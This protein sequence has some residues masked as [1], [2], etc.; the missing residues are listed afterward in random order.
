[1]AHAPQSCTSSEL[2][3]L[4]D[5][6]LL[7]PSG[8]ALIVVAT[9]SNSAETG[10]PWCP[11]C[12]QAKSAIDG[13]LQ[14]AAESHVAASVAVC[15]LSRDEWKSEHGQTNHPLRLHSQL[16]VGGIPFVARVVDGKIVG[17]ATEEEC[18]S[19][20]DLMK[21]LKT[22]PPP[23]PSSSAALPHPDADMFCEAPPAP[24]MMSFSS[25]R[26]KMLLFSGGKKE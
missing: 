10:M 2:I 24:K 26:E 8:R 19:M 25:G 6:A 3:T 1:M 9:A 5:H 18:F 20:E 23:P 16:M 21:R 15:A 17:R 11:D 7:Q 22:L 12:V 13:V 4:V 14:L